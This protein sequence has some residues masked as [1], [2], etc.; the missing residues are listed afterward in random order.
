MRSLAGSLL[1]LLTT[2]RF[3][4]WALDWKPVTDAELAMKTPKVDKGAD[5]E[6][7]FWE[8][9]VTDEVQGQDP[10]TTRANYLRMKIFTEKGREYAKVELTYRGKSRVTDVSGRT[11]KADGTIVP[12]KKDAIFE[13]DVVKGKGLRIKARSFTL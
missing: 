12:M 6:A 11:I 9:R 2:F 8:V 4:A 13:A 3:P 10:L 1:L 7:I 5:A